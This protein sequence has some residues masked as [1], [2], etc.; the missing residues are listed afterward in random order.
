MPA[1]KQ[2]IARSNANSEKTILVVGDWVVDEHWVT[3]IHRS[4][5]ASRSGRA[6]YRALHFASS[7]VQAFCG[8]GRTATILH[9]TQSDTEKFCQIIGVGLWHQDDTDVLAAMLDPITHQAQT[10]HRITRHHRDGVERGKLFNLSELLTVGKGATQQEHTHGTTRVMRIYQNTGAKIELLQRVDWELPVPSGQNVWVTD[11]SILNDSDLDKYLGRK[12]TKICAVV[13]KDICKGVI[14]P[15]LIRWLVNKVGAV[16]WFV[17]TKAWNPDWLR[18]LQEVDVRLLVI[19]QVAAQRAIRRGEV[20]CWITRSGHA[21]KEALDEIDKIGKQFS[22]APRLIIVTLPDGLSVLAR[23]WAR[24]GDKKK[25]VGI[26]Q[27]EVEPR[28]LAQDVSMASV[29]FPAAVANLLRNEDIPLERLLKS[30]IH[31]TQEWMSYEVERLERPQ[32][33]D[34]TKEP[35]VKPD[36]KEEYSGLGRWENFKWEQE[37][38]DWTQALSSYGIIKTDGN[39]RIELWRVMTEVDDYV[40]CIKS[41]RD[42]LQALVKELTA[43][44]AGGERQH[45]SCMLIASPG[46][47]KT[48]L[49]SRLAKSIGLRFLS[50]NITQMISRGDLLDCFDTIVTSQAQNREEPVLVFVDEVNAKLGGQ[51]V[52]DA[53]LAPLEEGVYIR[54]GKTFHIDPCV[55]VFAGTR[56]P[57]T[58]DEANHAQDDKTSDFV[59]RLTLA[60]LDLRMD[61]QERLS[62][63]EEMEVRVEKVYLGVSLLRSAFPDVTKVSEKV[64][65]AFH[66]L[67][68]N[69]AVRELKH[70]V[71]SFVDIQYGAVLARNVPPDW[72]K[73]L[74]MDFETWQGND[75]GELVEIKG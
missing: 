59:S 51:R 22:K 39:K 64:L 38:N 69:L 60:P 58:K 37:K 66:L 40:C 71:K 24:S 28:P 15:A 56:H 25:R 11:E 41:N 13:I 62:P 49:M 32:D 73:V 20:N 31:F 61:S 23:D 21:S 9:R 14:S 8:T 12:D 4:P 27:T 1:R 17:S 53:F 52:Y 18:E 68:N 45:R 10:P 74:A 19:P 72:F 57:T 33:W 42:V 35:V 46:S 43:F 16:P 29:F 50:F 2:K 6:H 54:G 36:S 75:E 3:G 65:K 48:Y 47:G 7:S 44:T 5:T 63:A 26:A 55:W 67:P 70:F 30:A 34:P